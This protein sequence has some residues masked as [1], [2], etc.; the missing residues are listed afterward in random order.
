[1]REDKP[2][3]PE[4]SKLEADHII[5]LSRGGETELSNLQTLCKV[6]N[7]R[8]GTSM[9][10]EPPKIRHRLVAQIDSRQGRL[11]LIFAGEGD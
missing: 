7:R 8:K 6:C 11:A 9:P 5:P 3:L 1:M 2:W 4:M 10:G